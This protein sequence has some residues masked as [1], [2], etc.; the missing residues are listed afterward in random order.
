MN[1]R[2]RQHRPQIEGLRW[3]ISGGA[4]L[5][6]SVGREFAGFTGAHVVEGY[7]LSE[8]SPVTHVG[9][10]FDEPRYSS[11]GFPLPETKCRIVDA[12]E[13]GDDV[14]ERPLPDG[15]VGELVVKGPQVMLGYWKDPG[16]DE[17]N[18]PSGL[19]AYRGPRHKIS[20]WNLP[21][22]GPKKRLDH[23]VRLQRLSRRGGSGAA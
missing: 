21:D 1:E 17:R 4:P 6:E 5:E 16:R 15:E 23:H 8:A 2:F 13:R 14:I 10:L 9:H 18:D 12:T 7:G 22:R 11:I 19:A 20:R 3:V